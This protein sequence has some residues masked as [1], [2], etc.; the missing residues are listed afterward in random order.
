[1]EETTSLEYLEENNLKLGFGRYFTEEFY[2]K[3]IKDN[4]QNKKL[5]SDDYILVVKEGELNFIHYSDNG[6][7]KKLVSSSMESSEFDLTL[8]DGIYCF[9]ANEHKITDYKK[10]AYKG[11]YKGKYLVCVYDCDPSDAPKDKGNYHE[12]VLLT[13]EVSDIVKIR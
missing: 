2:N 1:M 8:C 3:H 7:L 10:H 9:N 6:N 12:Y 11:I 13:E 5:L 4:E